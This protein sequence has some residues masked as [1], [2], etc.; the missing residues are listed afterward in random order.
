MKLVIQRVASTQVVVDS[1]ITAD[2]GIG[3]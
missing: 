3:R 1:K 2:I